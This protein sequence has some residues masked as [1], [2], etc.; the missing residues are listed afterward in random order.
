MTLSQSVV[1]YDAEPPSVVALLTERARWRPRVTH[2]SDRQAAPR[3]PPEKAEAYRHC[4][5][6]GRSQ[7][8]LPCGSRCAKK[9]L[10]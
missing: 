5:L 8:R 6:D 1:L 2:L 10:P 4:A 3:Q 7:A 9:H